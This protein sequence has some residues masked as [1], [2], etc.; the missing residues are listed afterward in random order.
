MKIEKG[1]P[2]DEA[3][4][5]LKLDLPSTKA[6]AIKLRG[7]ILFYAT[8][9]IAV[10]LVYIFIMMQIWQNEITPSEFLDKFIGWFL[11]V[12]VFLI[13]ILGNIIKKNERLKTY[14]YE[15]MDLIIILSVF[16]L[17][18]FI[19]SSYLQNNN[20]N[21]ELL[22]IISKES[23]SFIALLFISFIGLMSVILRI[24]YLLSLNTKE[25][26]HRALA[27]FIFTFIFGGFF[28]NL[29]KYISQI[30]IIAQLTI[31]GSLSYIYANHFFVR[32]KIKQK[33]PGGK[34]NP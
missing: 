16:I 17:G 4:L 8:Y 22:S 1:S 19:Y 20:W 15:L 14:F 21:R 9:I 33:F 34:F 13:N 23:I 24:S 27:L 3:P 18:Y 11:F 30:Q 5:E 28:I 25:G 10:I 29:I 6:L 2:F 31:G 7:I 12:M 26:R 32:C